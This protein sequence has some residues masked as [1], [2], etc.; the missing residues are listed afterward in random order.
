[1]RAGIGTSI[2]TDLEDIFGTSA[3]EEFGQFVERYTAA[4]RNGE[5][6]FLERI[7]AISAPWETEPKTYDALRSAVVLV[8]TELELVSQTDLMDPHARVPSNRI[9]VRVGMQHGYL[10]ADGDRGDQAVDELA[11]GLTFSAA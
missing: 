1:Y 10:L 2:R 4:E 3:R 6:A 5:A 9:E 8:D 7:V 11:D